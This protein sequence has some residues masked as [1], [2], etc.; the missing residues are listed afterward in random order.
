MDFTL[1]REYSNSTFSA[2]GNAFYSNDK[3]VNKKL[4]HRALISGNQLAV[5]EPTT[6]FSAAKH[7]FPFTR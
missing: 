2:D 6:P 5:I 3:E 4:V 7:A 1:H